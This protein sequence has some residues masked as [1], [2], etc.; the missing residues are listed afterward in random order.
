[1]SKKNK[2]LD[3]DLDELIRESV[4]SLFKEVDANESA[5][6]MKEKLRQEEKAASSAQRKKRMKEDP[7]E[8]AG[9]EAPENIKSKKPVQIKH[10]KV[11]EINLASISDKL[12]SIRSG[13][14]KIV[15]RKPII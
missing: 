2:L 5:E 10:E 4:K 9:D 7:K 8:S 1:M 15:I 11:P 6:N 14:I 12:N 3:F 13:K